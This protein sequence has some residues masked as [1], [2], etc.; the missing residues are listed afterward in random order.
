MQRAGMSFV[1]DASMDSHPP[2]TDF[3]T[4]QVTL[5]QKERTLL[6]YWDELCVE[7]CVNLKKPSSSR[8]VTI[9]VQVDE[10]HYKF[11]QLVTSNR[12]ACT[13]NLW[14]VYPPQWSRLTTLRSKLSFRTGEGAR[15][16]SRWASIISLWKEESCQRRGQSRASSRWRRGHSGKYV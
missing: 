15:Y 12:A 5:H 3:C 6:A 16:D 1:R 13:C 9:E 14:V 7:L 8:A 2:K 4:W 11:G 10:E